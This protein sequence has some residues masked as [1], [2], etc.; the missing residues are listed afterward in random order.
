MQRSVSIVSLFLITLAALAA[1]WFWALAP[2]MTGFDIPHSSPW[3]DAD[4]VRY[5]WHFRLVQPEW[6]SSPPNYD[7]GQWLQ[8]ELLARLSVVFLVWVVSNILADRIY[9]RIHDKH[10]A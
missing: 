2:I 5:V 9:S 6:V 3:T 8:A 1:A 10:V 7:Y 4:I